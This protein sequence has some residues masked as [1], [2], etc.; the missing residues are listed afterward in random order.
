MDDPD[1]QVVSAR[2]G[3]WP[4]SI[5][6]VP[7]AAVFVVAVASRFSMWATVLSGMFGLLVI[8]GWMMI[9]VILA[10]ADAWNRKWRQCGLLLGILVGVW[11]LMFATLLAADYTHLFIIYP[12]YKWRVIEQWSQ[13]DILSIGGCWYCGIAHRDAIYSL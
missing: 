1:R 2:A 5:S 7:V 12:Y 4:I 6:C 8:F 11:P 10:I 13:S 9:V 3:L